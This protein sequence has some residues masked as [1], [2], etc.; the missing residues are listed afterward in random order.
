MIL[1]VETHWIL[2]CV[3]HQEADAPRLLLLGEFGR[4]EKKRGV[5]MAR[6][7]R[8]FSVV[9]LAVLFVLIVVPAKALTIIP[10]GP[11]ASGGVTPNSQDATDLPPPDCDAS[12]EDNTTELG[13]LQCPK[14]ERGVE[15]MIACAVYGVSCPAGKKHRVTNEMGQL[16]KCCNCKGEK[17]CWYIYNDG[18]FC[19][20]FPETGKFLC[21][22]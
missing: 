7:I 2:N 4:R 14:S 13:E 11:G 9:I 10:G 18:N 21:G 8:I 22:I 20:Y 17:R 6:I 5:P 15:C 16:Y 12:D 3:L 1:Y 19:T